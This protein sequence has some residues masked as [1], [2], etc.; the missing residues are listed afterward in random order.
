M[1]EYPHMA[2][3][4]AL[5]ACAGGTL[6]GL[7]QARADDGDDEL[8]LMD[9]PFS[10]TDVADAFDDHDPF[11][12]NIHVGYLRSMALGRVQREVNDGAA[13]DGRASRHWRDIGDYSLERNVLELGLD[14]G[15]FRDIMVYARLPVILSDDRSIRRLGGDDPSALLLDRAGGMPLFGIS[16]GDGFQ[17]PTR[18]GVDYLAVGA[19]WSILNQHRDPNTPTWVLMVEGRFNIGDPMHPCARTPG[20]VQCEMRVDAGGMAMRAPVSPGMT[21][22]TN[23][24]RIETRG[25][26]RYEYLEPYGGLNFQIEWPGSSDQF[27]LPSGG[28]AGY[29]NQRPPIVGGLV[30]GTAIIPWEDREHYQRFALDLRF[31]ADYV[32]EGRDYSP[33]YDALG[34]SDNPSLFMPTCEGN[35]GAMSCSAAGLRQTPWFGLT[36]TQ[37]HAR[38]GGRFALQMQAARYVRFTAATEV[39]HSPSYTI[40]Q[41]DACNPN[42][43]GIPDSDTARRGT[44]ESGIIN[45]HHRPTIDLPGQRFRMESLTEVDVSIQVTALF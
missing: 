41:S 18:S 38:I 15:I 35:P 34:S 6:G 21:R 14:I 5:F 17:S 42:A 37:S 12:V 4:A 1:A 10:Y 32:S 31:T 16:A 3:I 2:K 22:G 44:C 26:W 29:I 7:R 27:F 30:V 9:E 23:A 25:A 11:D 20:A 13:T 36:D 19:A 33:L 45:P 43:S 8:V 28:L 24:L 40:T 39:R